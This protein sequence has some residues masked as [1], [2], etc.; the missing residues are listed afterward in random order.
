MSDAD[1]VIRRA[2]PVSKTIRNA[3]WAPKVTNDGV[4]ILGVSPDVF[5]NADS[6]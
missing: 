2:E 6:S 5:P 3:I 4:E 1:S